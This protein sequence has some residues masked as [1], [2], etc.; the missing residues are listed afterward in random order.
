M[1]GMPLPPRFL[2]PKTLLSRSWIYIEQ[3]LN[4]YRVHLIVFT[5][6]PLIF[7]A[8]MYASNGRYHIDYTDCLF[9]CVSAMTVVGEL[10]FLV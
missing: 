6:T 7:S 4:F 10:A 3:N 5:L 8:I 2:Q 1:L 9:N